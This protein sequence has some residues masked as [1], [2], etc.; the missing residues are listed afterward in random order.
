MV[1]EE[2]INKIELNLRVIMLVSIIEGGYK[3]STEGD[4]FGEYFKSVVKPY[5]KEICSSNGEAR[6]L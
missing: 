5:L 1:L 3:E 2:G 4:N 6:I